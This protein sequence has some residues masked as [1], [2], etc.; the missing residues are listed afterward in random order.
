MPR[1]DSQ[2]MCRKTS[3]R[4]PT[5]AGEFQVYLYADHRDDKE[6]LALV[7][8]E[9]CGQS[10]V[11]T[12]LHSECFTGD[13]L[14]SQRCDCG[15]QL[16]LAMSSIAREGAGVVLYLRQE[17]RGIGLLDKLRA[18]NLQDLG[19]DTVA[20]NLL[21]GHEADERDYGVAAR[22]LQDLGVLSVRLLTNN[23]AK[24]AGLE[25]SGIPV[26]AR[27]PLEAPLTSENADYLRAKA[28]RLHH[29]LQLDGV[30]PPPPAENPPLDQALSI[31]ST[32]AAHRRHTGRPYVTLT[33]AQSLDGSIAGRPGHPLPL[34]GAASMALTHSLRAAHDAILVGIGTVLADNPNLN[35][36]LVNGKN[37]QPVIVDSRLRFPVYANLLR[38]G[39]TPWIATGERADAERQQALEAAGARVLRVSGSNGW[40]DLPALLAQLGELGISSLM[41]EGGAQ[42]ITSFLASRLVDQVVV[43]IAPLLVGGLRAVDSLGYGSAKGLPRLT[44]L[45]YLP[46]G[47]DLVLRGEPDW[48]T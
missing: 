41:V 29:S 8:G 24:V 33:Y 42:I 38:H 40:V 26:T 9:I 45:S 5:A 19:Y 30:Q 37:P 43:T 47:D 3:A 16:Q 2:T 28:A 22:I 18:Y 23:P 7:Y 10:E 31:L 1:D 14:G 12:R 21:L 46:L 48:S 27:L 32:A 11:L 6:H 36:R 15:E 20:A 25:A 4:I 39:R 17:G 13:V 44:R 35:V 34:S